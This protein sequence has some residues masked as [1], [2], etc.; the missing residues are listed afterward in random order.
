MSANTPIK[1]TLIALRFIRSAYG[2][3]S[4]SEEPRFRT[5]K[6]EDLQCLSN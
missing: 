4:V 1:S 3:R 5:Y 6:L 2:R